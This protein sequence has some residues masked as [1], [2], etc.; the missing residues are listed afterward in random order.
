M[1]KKS[2]N[3]SLTDSQWDWKRT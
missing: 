2:H 1:D 3:T